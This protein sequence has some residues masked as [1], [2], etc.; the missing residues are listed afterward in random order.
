[1]PADEDPLD[2]LATYLGHIHAAYPELATAPS[3]LHTADGQFN[4]IVFAGDDLIFRFPRSPH[5]AQGHATQAA[6][7]RFLRGKLPPP[8]PELL[9]ASED[10]APWPRK[11]IGYRRLPGEPLFADRRPRFKTRPCAGGWRPGWRHSCAPSTSSRWPA[12]RPG[13]R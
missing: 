6:V 4:D 9:Y 3:R 2:R 10:D 12:S 7:L 13:C 5:V 8:I 11:F 1:M